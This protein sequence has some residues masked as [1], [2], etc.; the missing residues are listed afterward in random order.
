MLALYG[1]YSLDHE[2]FDP[3]NARIHREE[4]GNET[5]LYLG[6]RQIFFS[7]EALVRIILELHFGDK[8]REFADKRDGITAI[9]S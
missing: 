3:I 2:P 7:W 9:Q 6:R 8:Y 5:F 4:L 1:D